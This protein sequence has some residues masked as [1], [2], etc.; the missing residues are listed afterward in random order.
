MTSRQLWRSVCVLSEQKSHRSYL[1]YTIFP[2]CQG[3]HKKF[4]QGESAT[5]IISHSKQYTTHNATSIDFSYR[6]T[7]RKELECSVRFWWSII[8]EFPSYYIHVPPYR[9]SVDADP[10]LWAEGGGCLLLG[11]NSDNLY[12]SAKC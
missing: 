2:K 7:R 10:C 4:V 1:M 11:N 9:F 8:I 5:V 3:R 6:S 12:G